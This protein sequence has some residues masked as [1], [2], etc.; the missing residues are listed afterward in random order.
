MSGAILFPG[1][2]PAFEQLRAE[3][4]AVNLDT[5]LDMAGALALVDVLEQRMRDVLRDRASHAR[6]NETMRAEN[7]ALEEEASRLRGEVE[8]LT[9]YRKA[10]K[11]IVK[12]VIGDKGDVHPSDVDE[13]LEKW[14][15]ADKL[16]TEAE[17][18]M[19]WLEDVGLL[20][21]GRPACLDDKRTGPEAFK[22]TSPEVFKVITADEVR[23]LAELHRQTIGERISS[24]VSAIDVL[25]NQLGR[26]NPAIGA[27]IIPNAWHGTPEDLA[28][29]LAS[30]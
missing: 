2:E 22:R 29:E 17:E 16:S 15:A 28:R 6:K 14:K 18:W 1:D 4:R 9:D 24:D 26:H 10:F 12:E 13:V 23:F 3:L 8:D 21:Q 11:R 30:L 5:P 7:S 27:A 25:R 20:E 19:S